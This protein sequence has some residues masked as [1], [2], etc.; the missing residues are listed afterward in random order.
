MSDMTSVA[1]PA[2]GTWTL[3]YTAGAFTEVAVINTRPNVTLRIRVS[4]TGA[5]SDAATAGHDILQPNER[6]SYDLDS[7]DKL[8]ARPIGSDAGLLTLWV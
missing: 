4:S 2:D 3:V 7:G 6:N 8:L 1:V 5:T